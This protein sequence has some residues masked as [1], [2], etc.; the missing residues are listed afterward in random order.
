[1]SK[2]VFLAA[3]AA[4]VL[5]LPAAA[6]D[7]PRKGGTLTIA[8]NADIRSLDP[9]INRD[10]NTDSVAHMIYEGLVG[11]RT[12]LSVG[13]QLA[14]S[15]KVEDDGRTYRFTLRDGAKFHNGAAVTA[16][17]VK[18]SWDRQIA[19]K[20]WPCARFFNGSSGIKVEAVEAPDAATVVYRLEKP[21]ALFL[22]QLANFQC[23]VVAIHPASFDGEGKWKDAIGTG[24]F[25]LK[26]WKR[27][28]YI[29]ME[30]VADYVP[31]PEPASGYAGARVAHVDNLMVRIIPDGSAA[32]AAMV[33]GAVDILPD[34][35]A[36]RIDGL[37]QKGMTVLTAPG[38]G[39]SSILIQTR[40]PLLA[41]VKIR[42]AIAHALDLAEI[43]DVRSMGLTKANP[44]AV[45]A[46]TAYF[47]PSFLDWPAYDPKKAQALLKEAGYKGET[48]R[49]QTN[50][51]Y[52]GMYD[53]S[54]MAQA[55]LTAAGFKVELEVLEWA[56]Q[57]DNYLKG[58]FQLQSFSYSARLDP[59]LMYSALIGD[60]EKLK[61]AQW[62][63]STAIKLLEEANTSLDEARRKAIFVELHKMVAQQVPVVGLYFDTGIEATGPK[64]RGYKPWA[65]GKPLPWGVWKAG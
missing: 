28:E 21:S 26:E 47:Q 55:M 43:A 11:Y 27:G 17:D 34:V 3:A 40:D 65:A 46:A 59:G 9:G 25:K 33:S 24:P 48:I 32:E 16:A 58:N 57:L 4:A 22:K 12:D 60:K 10:G 54:V 29:S 44:S 5:A 19:N 18:S 42:Q 7:A 2:K 13:S 62:E 36:H 61:W 38:L 64:I 45:A 51:R 50:K 1:M 6:Q 52:S 15:W 8:L 31:N 30:R 63:D 23:A 14:K 37:K 49:L 39:W 20:A 56:T 41:N 35:D 53:N